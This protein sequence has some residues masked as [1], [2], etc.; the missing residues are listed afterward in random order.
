MFSRCAQFAR[1]AAARKSL[2]VTGGRRT[3][4]VDEGKVSDDAKFIVNHLKVIDARIWLPGFLSSIACVKYLF[5]FE[6]LQP[7]WI[8]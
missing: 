5:F 3:L 2:D 7:H 8:L 1:R 6:R 4:V